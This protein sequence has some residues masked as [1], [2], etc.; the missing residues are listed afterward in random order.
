MESVK[1]DLKLNEVKE[2]I[3]SNQ[4][5]TSISDRHSYSYNASFGKFL[6][7]MVIQVKNKID[8][9]EFTI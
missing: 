3:P 9:Q 7:D 6:P 8:Q 4:I 5:F 1:M 2:I